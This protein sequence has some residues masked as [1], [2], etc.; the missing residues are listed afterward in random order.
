MNKDALNEMSEGIERMCK[1]HE[2]VGRMHNEFNRKYQEDAQLADFAAAPA[3][4]EMVRGSKVELLP[5]HWEP[6]RRYTEISKGKG[7]DYREMVIPYDDVKEFIK[8]GWSITRLS[9]LSQTYVNTKWMN[10]IIA[11]EREVKV[12]LPN[13]V[14]VDH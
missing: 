8:N 4:K 14:Y 10:A 3:L 5:K 9:K 13:A 1:A 11:L 12:R 2:N 6:S 7:L